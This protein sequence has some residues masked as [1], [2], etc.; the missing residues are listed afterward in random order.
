MNYNFHKHIQIQIK[1]SNRILKLEHF[2]K[3]KKILSYQNP[4]HNFLNFEDSSKVD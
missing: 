4:C 1:K 2:L 3:E